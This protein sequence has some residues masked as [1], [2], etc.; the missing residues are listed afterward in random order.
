M[1]NG[2]SYIA[3]IK[4]GLQIKISQD[5]SVYFLNDLMNVRYEVPVYDRG[6]GL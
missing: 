4:A 5:G 6:T 2:S 3:G 1:M